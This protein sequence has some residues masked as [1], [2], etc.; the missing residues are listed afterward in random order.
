MAA[1][2]FGWY[3]RVYRGEDDAR[4]VIADFRR[5]EMAAGIRIA[6]LELYYC[7]DP[8]KR[9]QLRLKAP[10]AIRGGFDSLTEWWKPVRGSFSGVSWKQVTVE[11]RTTF[12]SNAEASGK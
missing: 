4:A 8:R 6:N 11:S 7:V 2:G 5:G 10:D 9:T 12:Y 3:E 1:R